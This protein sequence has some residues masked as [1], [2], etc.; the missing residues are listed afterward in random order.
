MT[1]VPID[2]LTTACLLAI[3]AAENGV[4]NGAAVAGFCPAG[5]G[6]APRRCP[7]D[8]G[9]VRQAKRS[10]RSSGFN[11]RIIRV[12]IVSPA[13][14]GGRDEQPSHMVGSI[15]IVRRT[16][17]DLPSTAGCYRATVGLNPGATGAGVG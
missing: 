17:E 4:V 11:R 15:N 6:A 2:V 16:V 13:R 1:I 14:R 5:A 9:A 7:P 10:G 12:I 3:S 8:T